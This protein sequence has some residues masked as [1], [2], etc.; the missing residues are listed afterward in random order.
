VPPL[1]LPLP[2]PRHFRSLLALGCVLL[3]AF[4]PRATAQTPYRDVALDC[5]GWVS[6]YAQHAG[7]GRLYGFGDIF[8]LY[9][10]DD[11][12]AT[13][14]FLQNSFT[15]DATFVVGV[16]V[17]PS[18]A[19]RV[20]FTGFKSTW[21][22]T[23]GGETWG[24]RLGDLT[25]KSNSRGGRPIVYHPTQANEL[26]LA[27]PRSGQ[28]AT[29][30]R[31][32]DNGASWASVGG[33]SFANE[34]AIT[35]YF[36]PSAPNEVWVGTR[37]ISGLSTTGGLWCSADDG[38]TWRK[39]WNNNGAQTQYYGAPQI[40]SIARNSSRVSVFATNT[41]TWRVTA[42]NWND[43]L[44]YTVTQATFA[45]QSVN[46]HLLADG[47]FWTGEGGSQTWAPK[48]SSDGVNWIDR[49]ITM[50]A[51][52]VPEWAT[53]AQL[54]S[55]GFKIFGR[56]QLVQDIDNP[57]RW[58]LC[59]GA[60]SYLSEDNGHTWRYQPGGMAGIAGWRTTASKRSSKR[61]ITCGRTASASR[62]P[63]SVW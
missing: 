2:L 6:G 42:T 22:S 58:L 25:L 30:W 40:H 57:N 54:T 27:S 51:A 5:G 50:T 43:P 63:A 47:S 31:S 17:H 34:E 33:T 18:D 19:N 38:A 14:Q 37:A 45:N 48:I 13:W 55:P 26:W 9:R 12:G 28:T 7:T 62:L 4:L 23:D 52:Y 44:T 41:G 1:P 56:D 61:P 3:S 53:P 10:S 16:T 60:A 21:T 39:I 32:T 35:I 20:A 36:L 29:L 15:E 49:Q 59:G 8:G 11:F 46:V 24:K